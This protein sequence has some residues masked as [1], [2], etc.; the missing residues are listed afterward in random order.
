MALN[1]EKVQDLI[2]DFVV[3]NLD[4]ISEVGNTNPI[5]YDA[6]IDALNLLSRK[7]GNVQTINVP[8]PAAPIATELNPIVQVGAKFKQENGKLIQILQIDKNDNDLNGGIVTYEREGKLAVRNNNFTEINRLIANGDLV[9]VYESKSEALDPSIQKGALFKDNRP[10]KFDT[11]VI[12]EIDNDAGFVRLVDLNG[13]YLISLTFARVNDHIKRGDWVLV[14]QAKQVNDPILS[15]NVGLNP[16]VQIQ[17]KFTGKNNETYTIIDIDSQNSRVTY[18][19][20]GKATIYPTT[21]DSVNSYIR[22]G[23]W[24]PK[25]QAKTILNPVVE[26]GAEFKVGKQIN[27]IKNIDT[28]TEIVKYLVV[29][30]KVDATITFHQINSR[31]ENEDWV[32]I[33]LNPIVQVGTTFL[34]VEDDIRFSVTK[35]RKGWDE[36]EITWENDPIT[37]QITYLDFNQNLQ[38]AAWVVAPERTQGVSTEDEIL[39]AIEGLQLLG[40]DDSKKEIIEL[41]KQLKQLKNKKP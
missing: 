6:V 15:I 20:S 17:A 35:I 4:Q 10:N 32:L 28:D 34:D 2:D 16:A 8:K 30:K 39:E 5:L 13:D 37:E 29:G 14:A 24:V 3:S 11:F 7:F 41:K 36:V 31:I 25:T 19:Q 27:K 40:D 26:I 9:H 18:Q 12:D 22:Y 38:D 33:S 1:K 23:L 21:F